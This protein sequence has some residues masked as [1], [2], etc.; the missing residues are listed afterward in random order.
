MNIARELTNMERASIRKLVISECAN[1]DKEYG[2]LVLEDACYMLGKRWTGSYCKY[3][4][5]AILSLATAL[6][7]ALMCDAETRRCTFCGKPFMQAGNWA[8]CSTKCKK[9][10]LRKQKRDHMRKKR[11]ECGK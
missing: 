1:Y 3:F 9:I 10:A 8:Y 4:R 6:E 7:T 2:C 5:N 11:A